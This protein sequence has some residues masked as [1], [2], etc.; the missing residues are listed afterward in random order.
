MVVLLFVLW[1]TGLNVLTKL[2]FS[3][4]VAGM[5]FHLINSFIDE[6]VVDWY[7]AKGIFEDGIFSATE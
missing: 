5:E 6:M 7:S 3:S 2:E 4:W 1:I